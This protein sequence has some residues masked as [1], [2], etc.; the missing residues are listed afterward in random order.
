M[1]RV[2]ILSSHP[3]FSQGIENLLRREAGLEIVGRETDVDKALERIKELQP[4]VVILECAEPTCDPTPVL[5][6]LLR[7]RVETKIIGL[8][9]QDNT[10]CIYRGEQRVV[11]EV[12]D[13]I[14][15][16]EPP[17]PEPLRSADLSRLNSS[18]NPRKGQESNGKKQI[19]ESPKI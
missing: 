10:M 2:F 8:N 12:K 1:K 19:T 13:L 3:L 11:K 7:E 5:T 18:Q 14:E 4:N 15:A 9:L 17:S 6:H 16:I